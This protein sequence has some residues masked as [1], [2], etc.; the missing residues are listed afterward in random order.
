[1]LTVIDLLAALREIADEYGDLPVA[2]TVQ[3]N[4]PL[5]GSLDSV[6]VTGRDG[7]EPK[8][9]LFANPADHGPSFFEGDDDQNVETVL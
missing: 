4:Y 2:V 8:L 7:E 5:A 9:H 1:M 3:P 6:R